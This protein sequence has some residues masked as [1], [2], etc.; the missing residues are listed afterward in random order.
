MTRFT[1]SNLKTVEFKAGSK[2]LTEGEQSSKVYLL[3]RGGVSVSIQGEE[4]C[5]INEEGSIF[6]EI[7]ALLGCPHTA[8]VTVVESATFWVIED[9][10][11][12]L[13]DNPED[14][15]AITEVLAARL[16]QMNQKF[17]E[18]KETIDTMFDSNAP[19][20]NQ[21]NTLILSIDTILGRS[22]LGSG[23]KKK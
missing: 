11:Q 19:L 20:K 1:T 7:S 13:R 8:T 4:V 21:L 14:A 6:G 9:L 23:T 17:L 10:R 12:H 22:I 2:I 16:Y 18:F 15:I 5:R 3:Q